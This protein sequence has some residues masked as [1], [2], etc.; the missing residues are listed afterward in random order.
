M[1]RRSL[2]QHN[3]DSVDFSELSSHVTFIFLSAYDIPIYLCL[4]AVR[5]HIFFISLLFTPS[6]VHDVNCLRFLPE[7]NIF[8]WKFLL[9]KCVMT[10]TP[11]KAPFSL[12][13]FYF[14]L[15]YDATTSCCVHFNIFFLIFFYQFLETWIE[16]K[17][18]CQAP[19]CSTLLS[20][21]FAVR[22]VRHE[23]KLIDKILWRRDKN[24]MGAMC[25]QERRWL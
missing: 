15:S 23:R 9:R 14:R 12:E 11:S 16:C 21:N 17:F 22:D 25:E 5:Y 1:L 18:Q 20:Q 10:T 8:N 2:Q 3:N 13:K 24:F 19:T 4:Y 7:K 6:R